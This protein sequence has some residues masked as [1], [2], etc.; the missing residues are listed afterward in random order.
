MSLFRLILQVAG[1]WHLY[2]LQSYGLI[3]CTHEHLTKNHDELWWLSAAWT[4]SAMRLNWS[5]LA[6]ASYLTYESYFPCLYTKKHCNIP[7][8]SS[9]STYPFFPE[10]LRVLGYHHRRKIHISVIF[11]RLL[12]HLVLLLSPFI[13][14]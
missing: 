2:A 3:L 1:I 8:L 11:L 14:L 10:A 7:K 4:I 13:Y 6:T 12:F 9:G 5:F